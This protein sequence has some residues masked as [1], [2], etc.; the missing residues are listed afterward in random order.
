MKKDKRKLLDRLKAHC[1]SKQTADTLFVQLQFIF[2]RNKKALQIVYFSFRY[3]SKF[4][5]ASE[6][7]YD[8]M[9]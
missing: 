4:I 5:L 3:L 1:Y 9:S 8:C 7:E 2:S 6:L